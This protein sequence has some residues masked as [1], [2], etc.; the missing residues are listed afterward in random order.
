MLIR[1]TSAQNASMEMDG[2]RCAACL[3]STRPGKRCELSSAPSVTAILSTLA[4]EWNGH[5]FKLLLDTMLCLNIMNIY[6]DVA[7]ISPLAE[8]H[9]VPFS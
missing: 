2:D 3:S 9:A 1:T 4:P 6:Y 7:G 8:N 5:V